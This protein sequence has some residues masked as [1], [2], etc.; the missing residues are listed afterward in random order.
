MLL[1][2]IYEED[3]RR[4]VELICLNFDTLNEHSLLAVIDA[5]LAHY[6]HKTLLEIGFPLN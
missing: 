6:A 3:I 5:R 1:C 4:D 2:W